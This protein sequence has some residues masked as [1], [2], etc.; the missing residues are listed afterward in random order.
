MKPQANEAPRARGFTLVELLVV[1]AIISLLS[2]I[3]LASLGQAR[4]KAKIAKVRQELTQMRTALYLFL[5]DKRELPPVNDGP[6]NFDGDSDGDGPDNCTACTDPPNTNVGPFQ[7]CAAGSLSGGWSQVMN[8]LM[9]P[10]SK[11]ISSRIDLDPW[12]NPFCYD[13]NYQDQTKCNKPTV[14]WSMGPD[15]EKDTPQEPNQVTGYLDDDIGI[16]I[17]DPQC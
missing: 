3:V 6:P 10:G 17:Y 4:E 9:P 16:F 14:L 8:E 5:D 15:G 11:Y 1:I 7:K 12:G 13:D 2:S